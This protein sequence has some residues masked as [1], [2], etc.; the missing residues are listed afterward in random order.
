[1]LYWCASAEN[2]DIAR[3][4]SGVER[5]VRPGS[6]FFAGARCMTGLAAK[7]R[8]TR[9]GISSHLTTSKTVTVAAHFLSCESKEKR[10]T[11]RVENR[12]C[13]VIN[14]STLTSKGQVTI[15][16][17]IREA[18]GLSTGTQLSFELTGGELRVRAISR[19][20]WPDLWSLA[21]GAPRP[22]KPV[23]VS[24]AIQAAVRERS[25]R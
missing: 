12:R 8:K 4:G 10:E 21:A 3:D 22:P 13:A 18:L 23:D 11:V 16:L 25:D 14:K 5:N 9:F 20:S 24:A 1:M 15:P 6:H 19:K 17:A 2:W 7:G